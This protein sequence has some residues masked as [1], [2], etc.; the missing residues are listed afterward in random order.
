MKTLQFIYNKETIDFSHTENGN[1]MVNATQ[2]ATAFGKRT[3]DFL[4]TDHAKEF[5]KE[6]ENYLELNIIRAPNGARIKINVV[7]N[8]GRNGIFFERRFALKFATWLN[9]KFEFWVFDKIDQ[10]ILGTYKQH[11]EATVE[12]LKAQE[13][14]KQTQSELLEKYPDFQKF[15]DIQNKVSNAGKKQNAALKVKTNEI[16]EELFPTPKE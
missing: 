8:R 11:T 2:M 12:K 13:E 9:V 1:L 14:L 3:K 16:M 10:I 6:L 7:E 4:K 5:K 15:L